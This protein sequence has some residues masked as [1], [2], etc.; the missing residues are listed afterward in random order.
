MDNVDLMPDISHCDYCNARARPGSPRE[1]GEPHP[2]Q[3]AI[4]GSTNGGRVQLS[5]MA[6]NT[7]M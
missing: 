4:D 3:Y 5:Q 7:T 6:G 1:I 2:I